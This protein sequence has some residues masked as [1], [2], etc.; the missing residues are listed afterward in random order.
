[1][2]KLFLVHL[3]YYDDLSNGVFESH[4]NIF[5]IAS[6]FQEARKIAKNKSFVKEKKMHIDGL[7]LI[8]KIDGFRIDLKKEND[9]ITEIKSHHFRELSTKKT[10]T[11]EK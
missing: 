8:E 7:Q 6:D 3:G 4:T 1:M 10:K 9:V 5:V 2:D 11:N